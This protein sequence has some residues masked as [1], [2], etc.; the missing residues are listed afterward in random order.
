MYL[1]IMK[2]VTIPEK[3]PKNRRANFLTGSKV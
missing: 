1:N 2:P 3:W